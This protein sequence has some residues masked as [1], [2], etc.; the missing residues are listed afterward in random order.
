MTTREAY[1]ELYCYAVSH[2]GP[3]FILQHVV[4]A[5][6]AQEASSA[7]KPIR[8]VFSLVGLYLH[9]ERGFTGREVQLAHMK[10]GRD[11]REWPLVS[12]PENRGEI[13][14]ENVLAA[15]ASD[16]DAMIHEWCRSVWQ[17][18]EKERTTIEDLLRAYNITDP[19]SVQPSK[20]AR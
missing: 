19:V 7:D 5:F 20:Q 8:L 10:L 6:G 4:D 18:Y 17:A 2:S 16:R 9:V 15:S 12:I 14:A 1:D 3:D 11:K 13:S